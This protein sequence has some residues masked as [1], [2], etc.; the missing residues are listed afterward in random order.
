MKRSKLWKR[1]QNGPGRSARR[2]GVRLDAKLKRWISMLPPEE[3]L[4]P[5]DPDDDFTIV[6]PTRTVHP[7]RIR[8]RD[9]LKRVESL[10]PPSGLLALSGEYI[11]FTTDKE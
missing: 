9:S 3:L 6:E 2:A 1:V 4:Q 5:D 7:G 10:L 8:Y 11:P